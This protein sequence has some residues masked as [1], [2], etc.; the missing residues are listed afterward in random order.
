GISKLQTIGDAVFLGKGLDHA[1]VE[2]LAPVGAR[3]RDGHRLLCTGCSHDD[4]AC[5]ACRKQK[6][7]QPVSHFYPPLLPNRK[8]VFTPRLPSANISPLHEF[9][10]C[11]ILYSKER[12]PWRARSATPSRGPCCRA[13]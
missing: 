12:G 4:H 13:S 7:T 8:C 3:H 2:R 6:N 5:A 9:D 1:F 10:S 11:L